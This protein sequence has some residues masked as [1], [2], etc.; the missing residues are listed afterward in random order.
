MSNRRRIVSDSFPDGQKASGGGRSI[1]VIGGARLPNEDA[2]TWAKV[3]RT[4]TDM[5]GD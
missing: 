4:A 1:G 3:A 2:Y 5:A